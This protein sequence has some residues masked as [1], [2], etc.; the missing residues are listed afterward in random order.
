MVVVLASAPLV[1]TFLPPRSTPLAYPPYAPPLVERCAGW[2][3]REELLMS[4]SPWAV[5]WYGDR[6]CIWTTLRLSD[7]RRTEDFYAVN[8]TRKAIKGLYLT[9][10]TLDGPFFDEVVRG[11]EGSWGHFAATS[12]LQK[13]LPAGF[14]LKHAPAGYLDK[15]QF[16]LS[17]YA[18]WG[19]PGK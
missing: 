10:V 12:V 6:Q 16:F 18:R 11:G 1:L 9:Q 4:D 5:A 15:G 13:K 17:D 8:D 19:G 7:P 3:S 2:M 14:P